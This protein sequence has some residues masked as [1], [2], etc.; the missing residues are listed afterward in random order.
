MT[1]LRTDDID[2]L[3]KDILLSLPQFGRYCAPGD[4]LLHVIL[5][6][7]KATTRI[8]ARATQVPSPKRTEYYLN[9]AAYISIERRV[10]RP[11]I[12]VQFYLDTFASL[13]SLSTFPEESRVFIVDRFADALAGLQEAAPKMTW[14]STEEVK[15]MVNF[16][17][18]ACYILL[19]VS[20]AQIS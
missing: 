9:L 6:G 8:E 7:A 4:K 5:A 13:I 20:L 10:A 12:L 18:D 15:R 17:V 11:T 2:I 3:V 19:L 1:K 16:V 14:G